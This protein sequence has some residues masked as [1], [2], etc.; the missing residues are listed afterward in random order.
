LLGHLFQALGR[1][2]GGLCR[3]IGANSHDADVFA[4]IV[5]SDPREFTLDV[6]GRTGNAD[7]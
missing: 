7:K 6:L 1:I 3:V 2:V 5:I 4:G